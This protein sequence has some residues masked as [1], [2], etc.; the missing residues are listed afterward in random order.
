MN[1]RAKALLATLLALVISHPAHAGSLI[2]R[3]FDSLEGLVFANATIR[4]EGLEGSA[5]TDGLG[6]FRCAKVRAGAHRVSISLADGR[7]LSSLVLVRDD[8][9]MTPAEFDVSRIIPPDDDY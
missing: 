6:F 9:A 2:G 8:R 7:V 5:S 4:I 3:V 1:D